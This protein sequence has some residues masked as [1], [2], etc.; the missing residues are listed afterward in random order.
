MKR[1]ALSASSV[2]NHPEMWTCAPCLSSVDYTTQEYFERNR[3][4]RFPHAQASITATCLTFLSFD[5][6]G[7]SYRHN[8]KELNY[9]VEN[10]PFFEYAARYWGHHAR[11]EVEEACKEMALK[12]FQNDA[13]LSCA[14]LVLFS[15][16]SRYY[17]YLDEF[18]KYFSGVHMSSLLGLTKIIN[19]LFEMGFKA[20]SKDG[21]GQTPLSLAA[22]IGHKAV[23]RLLLERDDVE[24]DSK[25]GYGQTPLS[26]AAK[27]GHE[28][29][30]R[31]LLERDDVEKN[32]KDS[33]GRTPLSLAAKNG[34]EAVVRLLLERD[35]VEK[36]SKDSEGQTP[37]F[38][39]AFEGHETVFRLLLECD[40]V[41]KDSKNNYGQTPLSLA[42]LA[43]HETM[44]RLLLERDDVEK[45]LQDNDGRTPLSLAAK[46]DHEAVVRLLL[47]RDDIRKVSKDD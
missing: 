47:K 15:Q 14:T 11:G 5:V 4:S 28:T 39:A 25:D 19:Y 37:L 17:K 2:R 27:N 44:V 40:D 10:N 34:H 46:N 21:Y 29:V 32:S 41:K 38:Y 33:D 26:F 35:D 22:K 16:D 13:K 42:A 31:L 7:Q 8:Y 6:F 23:V 20:D 1:A 18:P 30:F 12:L 43:G 24:K 45:N 9:F 3:E 36:D